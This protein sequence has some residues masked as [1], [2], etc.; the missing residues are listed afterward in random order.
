[1]RLYSETFGLRPFEQ[2]QEYVRVLASHWFDLVTELWA[3][4]CRQI[5]DSVS[6]VFSSNLVG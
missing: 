1:M 3:D 6:E 4:V 2:T 5:L